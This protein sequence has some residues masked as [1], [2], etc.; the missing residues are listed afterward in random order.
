MNVFKILPF[1]GKDTSGEYTLI[2]LSIRYIGSVTIEPS[3]E[4]MFQVDYYTDRKMI[5]E[6]NRDIITKETIQSQL[7]N[8]GLDETS[9]AVKA[10]EMMSA[11]ILHLLGGASKEERYAT[12]SQIIGGFGMELLPMS[13]QEGV[14]FEAMSLSVP[15][16][17]PMQE[18]PQ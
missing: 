12:L 7:I 11:A 3:S 1:P 10:N 9:A 5:R 17:T 16:V 18:I 15:A 4:G 13:E 14:L 8:M 2:A 6:A